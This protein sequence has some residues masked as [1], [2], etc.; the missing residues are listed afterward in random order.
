MEEK[1]AW[2]PCH[3]Y[4]KDW[5]VE[6]VVRLEDGR[7]VECEY[8]GCSKH[9][10]PKPPG[11]GS[12]LSHCAGFFCIDDVAKEWRYLNDKELQQ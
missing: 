12:F 3:I 4:P 10:P 11:K 9:I 5:P 1:D 6:I 2:R 8:R 7:E